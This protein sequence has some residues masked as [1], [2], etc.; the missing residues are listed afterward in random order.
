MD[1]NA[2]T[3]LNYRIT[4]VVVMGWVDLDVDVPLS[5]GFCLGRWELGK[6][7]WA[8]GQ[9]DGTSKSKSTQPR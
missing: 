2:I 4:L 8:G 7:R 5:A 9:D 1:A 6:T 3:L